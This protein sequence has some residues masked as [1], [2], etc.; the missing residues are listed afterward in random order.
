M[1]L[2]IMAGKRSMNISASTIIALMVIP[3]L[4]WPVIIFIQEVKRRVLVWKNTSFRN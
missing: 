1:S 3:V 4:V 2:I